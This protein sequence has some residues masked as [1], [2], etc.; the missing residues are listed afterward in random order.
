[1]ISPKI[2]DKD[3][4]RAEIL[5]SATR[6]FARRGYDATRIEDVALEAGIA[7]GTV[8]IYFE[9]REE[10][11]L[12]AFEEFEKEVLADV[13]EALGTGEPA[14]IRLRSIVS[15]LLSS[16]EAEP[17]LARVVLD[18][19]AAGTF[20]ETKV[21]TE[22]GIDFGRI[23]A[24]Y[25]EM[26]GGLLDEA[27]REGSVRSDVPDEAP[28]VIVGTIEGILLQWIVAPD[29]VLLERMAEPILDVLL[30]GL[31]TREVW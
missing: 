15:A 23:Y 10:I 6:V 18:F 17:D 31:S 28:A 25:R 24:E 7:K 21:G 27:K 19:W 29:A 9:S 12:S 13:R 2:V 8:Y 4:R 11:L 14:L 30:D 3:E 26:L 5:L 20:E 16:M 1:M 22:P